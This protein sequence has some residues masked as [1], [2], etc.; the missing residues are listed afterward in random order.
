MEGHV[1]TIEFETM[2]AGRALWL[3]SALLS[4]GRPPLFERG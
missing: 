2:F 1:T 4:A 3:P